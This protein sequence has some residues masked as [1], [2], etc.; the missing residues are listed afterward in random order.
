MQCRV[1]GLHVEGA[2]LVAGGLSVAGLRSREILDSRGN[3]TVETDVILAC[4]A[5]GRAA[6]PSGASTGTFEA[7]ELRDGDGRYHGRGV[8]RATENVLSVIAPAVIGM[9][10]GD[11]EAFDRRLLDL[12]GTA[13]KARLGANALLSVSLAA[14]RAAAAGRGLPLYRHLREVFPR[15]EHEMT[16]PVPMLNVINGGRHADNNLDVQELMIVPHGFA[17]FADALRAAAEVYAG[18][19]G[20]LAARKLSTA[21]GD[22]GGFAP[23]LAGSEEGMEL[24]CAAIEDAGYRPGNDVGL[25]LDVAASSFAVPDGDRYRF[26]GLELTA[27]ELTAVYAGWTERYPLLSLEDPLD[28]EDWRGWGRLTASLGRRVQVVGD[29]LFV[30]CPERI[31]RGIAAGAANSVLIKVNQIGTLTETVKAI[32]AAREAGWTVVVSHRS[33]ETEDTTIADLA[34]A[35][36]AGQ[37]K[38]GAPCRGERT[39]KYNRLLR[40]EEELGAPSSYAGLMPVFRQD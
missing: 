38:A 14:A 16:L 25:A 4:G 7:V 6:V 27:E 33:G 39:G 29:D 10:P 17:S 5:V 23:D 13:N 35:L 32:D 36:G 20:L 21:V 22:E 12:D 15:P 24:L 34:V 2:D 31:R 8:R 11:Q 3:P 18:L 26:E 9:D 19:R 28:E 37:I 1:P 30:T 40:I